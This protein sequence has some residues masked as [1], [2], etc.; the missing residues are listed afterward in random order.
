MMFKALRVRVSQGK[1]FI[2]DMRSARPVGFRGLPVVNA[3]ACP[4][5]CDAC[6]GACPTAAIS[7][8]PLANDLGKGIL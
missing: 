7:R 2:A 5:E 8:E 4:P 3:N 1:Q 6:I